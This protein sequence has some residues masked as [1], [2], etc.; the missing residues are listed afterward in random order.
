MTNPYDF[1]RAH[2]MATVPFASHTGVVI[3]EVGPGTAR[4]HL[5][6][7]PETANHIGTPHAGAVFTLGETV[8]GAAMAG[9]F[10]DIL[11]EL[12]PVAAE[13]QIGFLKL[14][15]GDLVAEG[16]IDADPAALRQTLAE[17]G[18]VAFPVLVTVRDSE[19]T[20]VNRMTVS[21]HVSRARS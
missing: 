4:A 19:G 15:K 5:P 1:I 7:R 16:R 3:D 6:H 12:R 18:K 8:S 9:A 11:L 2:L 20:E 10:A 14:A 21:W 17:A 13:A